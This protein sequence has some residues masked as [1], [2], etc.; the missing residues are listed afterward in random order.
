MIQLVLN[1][2]GFFFFF[3]R[4]VCPE[5]IYNLLDCWRNELNVLMDAEVLCG[6][7]LSTHDAS[8]PFGTEVRLPAVA[9]EADMTADCVCVSEFI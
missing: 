3:H 2:M 5:L 1:V 8:T 4:R 6:C 7:S 9:L